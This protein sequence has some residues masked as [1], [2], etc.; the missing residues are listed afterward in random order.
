MSLSEDQFLGELADIINGFRFKGFESFDEWRSDIARA[1]ASRR[2]QI[3]ARP[4]ER[5]PSVVDK[6]LGRQHPRT[7]ILEINGKTVLVEKRR[8]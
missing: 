4:T 7:G 2:R 3:T 8:R 5:L 1:I 6:Y